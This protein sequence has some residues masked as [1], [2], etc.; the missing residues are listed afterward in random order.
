MSKTNATFSLDLKDNVSKGAG[1]AA[2]SLESLRQTV[3]GSQAQLKEYQSALRG[4]RGSSEEVKAAKDA[5][6]AK[7]SAT[8][9]AISN[10]TLAM[11]K[12]GVTLDGLNKRHADLAK[13]ADDTAKA[14]AKASK[15]LGEQKDLLEVLRGKYNDAGGAQGL[16]VAGSVAVAA[17]IVAITAAVVSG[18]VAFGKWAIAGA[19]AARSLALMR[20][21]ALGSASDAAALGTQVDA[22]ASRVPLSREKIGQLGLEMHRAGI[23]GQTLVDSMRA[24]AGATAGLDDA[25][26]NQ[27]KGLLERGKLTQRFQINPLELQGS[28][29]K[30]DDVAKKL[31]GNLGVGIAQARKAL[32]EG[33]VKL[34]DGAKALADAVDERFGD[35]NKRK[36][37][38]LDTQALRLRENFGKLTAGIRIDPLLEGVSRLVALFGDSTVTGA[39]LKEIVTLA[40]NTLTS[41]LTKGV[42]LAEAGFKRVVIAGLDIA[43]MALQGKKSLEE[44]FSQS[45]LSRIDWLALGLKVIETHGKQVAGTMELIGSA[46]SAHF[47]STLAQLDALVGAYFRIKGAL[48]SAL[49]FGK[50]INFETLG[51]DVVDGLVRGLMGGIP[52]VSEAM[53]AL[54]KGLKDRFTGDM[55]IRSPSRVMDEYGQDTGEGLV[56]GVKRKGPAVQDA[57]GGLVDVPSLAAGPGAVPTRGAGGPMQVVVNAPISIQATDG[58]SVKAA[59]PDVVA[60][61]TE[62]LERGLMTAGV[63]P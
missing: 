12:Q 54:A 43:I 45:N 5:L 18:V 16:F 2:S 34:S 22:L 35:T 51:K 47:G 32:V 11:T 63:S 59:L 42:P 8:Q 57:V 31:S 14:E 56:Q 10:A 46:A 41:A 7:I 24:I 25:A 30:L 49:D 13:Q 39:A 4:L 26:G 44:W 60:Q 58:A 38:G 53:G 3:N 33:R 50:S 23:G 48:R 37:L 55:K 52:S 61:L 28:G 15:E 29:L 1:A 27:L 17:A 20:E 36:L 62:A 40:G 21:S 19:D 6:R 9:N